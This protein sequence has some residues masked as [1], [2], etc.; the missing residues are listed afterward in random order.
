MPSGGDCF[1]RSGKRSH[2]L[3]YARSHT[4]PIRLHYGCEKSVKGAGEPVQ[5]QIAGELRTTDWDKLKSLDHDECYESRV[6][7]AYERHHHNHHASERYTLT[8]RFRPAKAPFVPHRQN[9]N[10]TAEDEDIYEHDY[11]ENY[12]NIRHST[13]GVN[14]PFNSGN[15]N[16][17]NGATGLGGLVEGVTD[18]DDMDEILTPPEFNADEQSKQK[19]LR[20]NSNLLDSNNSNSKFS[21]NDL[22]RLNI[23]KYFSSRNKNN[24]RKS[25]NLN[26]QTNNNNEDA[27][28]NSD[29][30]DDH[31]HARRRVEQSSGAVEQQRR[32]SAALK[33][34]PTLLDQKEIFSAKQ[35]DSNNANQVNSDPNN[36]SVVD[37]AYKSKKT[38][39]E[40]NENNLMLTALLPPL[41]FQHTIEDVNT[42]TN[43][44]NVNH[45]RTN[46]RHSTHSAK[47][48]ESEDFLATNEINMNFDDIYLSADGL[49]KSENS[50][51][52]FYSNQNE[53]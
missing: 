52:H 48:H 26:S 5:W 20:K 13:I 51:Q 18:M 32:N 1:G 3:K 28:K 19:P 21:F 15:N 45:L 37:V 35:I 22:T 43:N 30:S 53:N 8:K 49:R 39:R 34:R 14:N 47:R 17:S 38:S 50:F 23:D 29:I 12:S 11:D 24:L 4:S 33:N 41:E 7:E 9:E 27:R 44:N 25:S 10:E 16:N 31:L 6:A 36:V 40:L 46:S 42:T 2:K